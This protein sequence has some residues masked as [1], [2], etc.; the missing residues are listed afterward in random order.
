MGSSCAGLVTRTRG[1]VGDLRGA[2]R[3]ARVSVRVAGRGGTRAAASG[4]AWR[5]DGAHTPDPDP[6]ATGGAAGGHTP[7]SGTSGGVRRVLGAEVAAVAGTAPPAMH[8]QQPTEL[9]VRVRLVPDRPMPL[10]VTTGAVT[11]DRQ[12]GVGG[13]AAA[14][15]PAVSSCRDSSSP[16]MASTRAQT[17]TSAALGVTALPY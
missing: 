10:D 9:T 6:T 3:S 11:P 1:S 8:L 4:K 12:V 15:N 13:H 16:V 2:G 17:R 7:C 14:S 5:P